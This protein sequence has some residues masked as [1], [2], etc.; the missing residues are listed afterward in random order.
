[1]YQRKR[2]TQLMVDRARLPEGGR[3][4]IA[5]ELCP[6]L[7]LRVQ[8]TGPRWCV[9]WKE[10]GA[11]G[12]KR[13][14]KRVT[15]PYMQLAEARDRARTLLAA[16]GG[17]GGEPVTMAAALEQYLAAS[18]QLA[19]KTRYEIAGTFRRHILPEW[20]KRQLRE[21]TSAA[22]ARMLDTHTTGTAREIRK[23]TSGLYSWAIERGFAEN[24]PA[25]GLG[26]KTRAR[27]APP[28]DAGRALTDEELKALWTSALAMG[29]PYGDFYRVLMLTGQRPYEW[30]DARFSEIA[31]D[32]L[33]V[34][35]ER[36]K[37]RRVAHAI[38]LVPAVRTILN[39][40]PRCKDCD[41]LFHKRGA[42]GALNSTRAD[43][44]PMG[45]A[46]IYD[47]RK[48]AATRL[49][50]L[51]IEPYVIDLVQGRGLTPLQRTYIKHDYAAEKRAALAKYARHVMKVV[52]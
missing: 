5:D 44:L 25:A 52:G 40:L 20:G 30:R 48:T 42:C 46:V 7:V 14:Q 10:R 34:P 24:N 16:A 47:L 27:L 3:L 31:D 32:V 41:W 1:M 49:A 43:D 26:R 13:Q 2:L 50:E 17:R 22:L 29:Y 37:T 28:R 21:F 45:D 6:G 39:G 33:T 4:E 11:D 12:K 36:Y 15:L 38:P 9:F 23:Y 19:E 18:S 35:R 51:G 8:P